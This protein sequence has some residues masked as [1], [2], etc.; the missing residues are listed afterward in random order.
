MATIK[1]DNGFVNYSIEEN[2]ITIDNIKVYEQRKGTGKKMIEE[3]KDLAKELQLPIGLY[4]YP[5]DDTINQDDL[6]DFYYSCGFELD[7]DDSDGKL[8][9]WK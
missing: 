4:S 1:L 5:Q 2:E 3:L 9:I 7:P 8:F 6:N